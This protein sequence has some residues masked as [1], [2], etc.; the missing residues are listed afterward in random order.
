M[1]AIYDEN[2]DDFEKNQAGSGQIWL[3]SA[4]DD[5]RFGAEAIRSPARRP[6]SFSFL[7]YLYFTGW[8]ETTMPTIF[9]L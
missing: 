5:D 8:R 3:I 1:S 7:Y 4:E 6:D 2:N 9:L